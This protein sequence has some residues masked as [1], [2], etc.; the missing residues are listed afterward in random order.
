MWLRLQML[1]QYPLQWRSGPFAHR[2]YH[3]VW[4]HSPQNPVVR[5]P[6]TRQATR[7]GRV[8]PGIPRPSPQATPTH[9]LALLQPQPSSNQH[10]VHNGQSVAT[11]GTRTYPSASLPPPSPTCR[12][13]QRSL[14]SWTGPYAPQL[15][16]RAPAA[17]SGAKCNYATGLFPASYV[18]ASQWPLHKP[19]PCSPA[20]TNMT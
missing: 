8:I 2:A 4:P 11:R 12:L 16:A 10:W 7:K 5:G 18:I 6:R 3:S 17:A 9:L 1:W 20:P 15:A 13:W 19:W 14:I